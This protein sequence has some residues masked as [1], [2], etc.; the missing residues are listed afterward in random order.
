MFTV[1]AFRPALRRFSL[2][3][4]ALLT[5]TPL[6]L[7]AQGTPAPSA[8]DGFDPNVNG[9]V[10]AVAVQQDG[11]ILIA[12]DFTTVQPN[13]TTSPTASNR[14]ARLKLDGT[15]DATFVSNASVE[16]G[17]VSA[18]A[19][20]DDGK[21]LIGGTFT[22]VDGAG[23][24]YLARLNAD[25]TLD[26][27][28]NP[29]LAGA[30]DRPAP[31]VTSLLVQADGQIVI[32]GDF[33]SVNGTARNRIARLAKANG[34]LDP[35]FDPNANSIVLS[36]AQEAGGKILVGGGFTSFHQPGGT[37]A[38][39]VRNRLARLNADGSLDADFQPIID[40]AVAA[41]AVQPDGRIIVGGNFTTVNGTTRNHL[42]R[43][44]ADGTVDGNFSA[45]ANDRVSAIALSPDGGILVSGSFA[46]L[47][48]TG[49]GQHAYVGRINSDGSVDGNFNAAANA[50][51]SAVA[52]QADGSVIL[53][54]SFTTFANA[55][56]APLPRNHV[57]RLGG[58][59]A[60][61]ADFNPIANGRVAVVV[62]QADG[63]ILVGGDFTSIGGVSRT[64]LARLNADGSLDSSF[65][66]QTDGRVA[67]I[68]PAADGS[69]LVGGSFSKVNDTTRHFIARLDSTGKVDP[70][71]NPNVNNQVTAIAVQADGKIL[72]GGAF[73]SLQ[74]N[75]DATATARAFLARVNADG[76][77]DPSFTTVTDA[78]V[79][80]IRVLADGNIYIGGDFSTLVVTDAAGTVTAQSSHIRMA[81]IKP[82]GTIDETFGVG[83][84]GAVWAIAVQSDNSFVIAGSFG[85]VRDSGGL[86]LA[87]SN[88][89][90][91][92]ADGSLDS[93]YDPHADGTIT[94]AVVSGDKIVIGGIFKNLAPN[95]ASE[96]TARRYVARLNADG[97]VDADFNLNIADR[98]G[99][100]VAGL[101]VQTDGKLLVAGTF[102]S[103][104]PGAATSVVI[105]NRLARI[106]ADGT[107]DA[108]FD[109]DA[110]GQAAPTIKAMATQP[111]GSVLVAGSF[112]NFSG[113]PGS[114]FAR[115]YPNG[116][117]DALFDANVESDTGTA[118]VNAFAVL[119]ASAPIPTQ[120]S[121]FASLSDSGRLDPVFAPNLN[122]QLTGQVNRV[123]VQTEAQGGG[124][125]VGGSF[126]IAA[127][128]ANSVGLAR[129]KRDGSVDTSFVPAVAG[130]VD[131]IAVQSDG[132]ILIGGNFT[133]VGGTARNY[134][135]RLNADGTLDTTFD[136]NANA[137]VFAILLTGGTTPQ[138][139][140]AG[141][142]NTLQP[143]GATT[144]TTRQGIARL[145]LDGAI[146]TTFDPK[147]DGQV[148]ALALQSDGKILAGGL[149]ASFSPNAATTAVARRYFARINTDGTVDEAFTP[150]PNSSIAVIA[151]QSDG[152]ILAGGAFTSIGGSTH[153]YI[154]RLNADGSL[155]ATFKT[156]A[157]GSI[158]AIAFVDDQI[159]L[160][161]NFTALQAGDSTTI[162]VRSRIARVTTD[163]T[164]DQ[165]FDPSLNSTVLSFAATTD[166]ALLV[167]GAFTSL[168]SN[169]AVIVGGSF[170][171]INGAAE[172]E[173]NGVKNLAVLS[174]YGSLNGTFLPN[175]DQPVDAVALY[176][177][178]RFLAGGEF[179]TI[180]G[181]PRNHLARF[182]ADYTLD[183]SFDPNV[184]G[185][186]TALVL[187]PDGKILVGGAFTHV[188][189][190]SHSYLARLNADGTPDNS[191]NPAIS[192]PIGN[193]VLQPDGL[194]LYTAGTAGTIGRL[195]ADGS[196][197]PTFSVTADAPIRAVA[198]QAD[199]KIYVGGEFTQIGGAAHPHL[200]R[201]D[202]AGQP[203]AAF[204]H[205]TDGAVTTLLIQHDGK[206]LVAGAFSK[207]DG[208]AR[209]GVARIAADAPASESL[210]VDQGRTTL[211]WANGGSSPQVASVTFDRSSD[212]STWTTLGQA[213]RT[214]AGWQLSGLNLP[215]GENGAYYLRARAV[216]PTGPN[217]S[218]GFLN[219]QRV[220]SNLP[221][222]PVIVSATTVSGA[223]GSNFLYGIAAS[224]QPTAYAA[225]NLPPGLSLD[226]ATG[227][228]S[229]I[230][231]QSGTFHITLSA[232]NATGTGSTTLTLVIAASGGSTTTTGRL[233]NVSDRG[234]VTV[235]DPLIAGLVIAGA[236]PK[237]VLLRAIGPGLS[238]MGVT[239]ALAEPQLVLFD[240]SGQQ[241]FK[242]GAWVDS[243]VLR[244]ES[245]RL[246][247]TPLA[248]GSKDASVLI[249]LKPGIYTLHVRTASG[250]GI[251]L[252]EVYDASDD[253]PPAAD[254]RLVNLSGR[255]I[256]GT[257]DN[258]LIGGF[259][260]GGTTPKKVLLRGV[261]PGLSGQSVPVVLTDPELQLFNAQ[262][263][264]IA[265]NND[266]QAPLEV[267]AS[268]P[269][270]SAEDIA[271]A[272]HTTGAFPFIEGSKDAAILITLPPGIYTAVLRGADGG[273]GGAMVEIYDVP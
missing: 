213:G 107:L 271:A 108:G 205:E 118:T 86:V 97:T 172:I 64:G 5:M 110:G 119:P 31:Q 225:D 22:T 67:V 94:T 242:V 210:V 171:R 85:N 214:A 30:A 259:V 50:P 83:V 96:P 55:G 264:V 240:A 130:A 160:G 70:A 113:A 20:Q 133:S 168:Q 38:D 254:S 170:D 228:I 11:S 154:A 51:V 47:S 268:Y 270:A 216:L 155:D 78:I 175:P 150:Q 71:F 157:N 178:G 222:V 145:G 121:G 111:N 233:M 224:D 79:L 212:G 7:L 89:A 9:I 87:R 231:T 56:F 241:L 188:G 3:V 14:I 102:S 114:N 189:G 232:T 127:L 248:T 99:N 82:D 60:L 106:N 103:L 252:A 253:P 263:V 135:A 180:A 98:S 52:I 153:E 227:I 163:G 27:Q 258:I 53:G 131:A 149:F 125:L 36:L 58:S 37:G 122:A 202:S 235:S 77:V 147:P 42:V 33:T 45:G 203:D 186:V 217:S 112:A 237:T 198:V 129:Y 193:L 48:G 59:G 184:D 272:A 247:A 245:A 236:E 220:I 90:R 101:A 49:G 200:A 255:A 221:P 81:R 117:P 74:P 15:L 182:K 10:Y 177:D 174:S 148:L 165:A 88:V 201:L 40:N 4:F 219:T 234:N 123:V 21:I 8:A 243:E 19:L 223:S 215:T 176:A 208:L 146:D 69:I 84:D 226:P 104:Q 197:D 246:G 136:P 41:L 260:I 204:T 230:P 18:V 23:R 126:T 173:G 161:G 196:A 92:K 269:A 17:K 238:T 144:A 183:V 93:A 195:K 105:R 34:A 164:I 249:T 65:V 61:D 266:W 142:F 251:A 68:V 273:T 141:S 29:V 2:G 156:T 116:V 167:G 158:N 6:A 199:G 267:D 66:A 115:F 159:V 120:T 28:F 32:G 54:G 187:Q 25:G 185:T 218:S 229:G 244:D 91:F 100:Q 76:S 257:G 179:S 124:I 137:A 239:T 62:P 138:I 256:S 207:L 262:Q 43:L 206:V 63:K 35:D 194:I 192:G 152:K 39:A 250:E 128:G 143:N 80:A 209:Y 261:G 162:A 190:A 1:P 151:V 181:K 134:I 12:G 211:T 24:T 26:D 57:A 169:T 132:K 46:S 191:F 166:G 16:G 140:I 109:P 265:R 44:N 72:I 139:V 75:A 73:S 95:D 13:G